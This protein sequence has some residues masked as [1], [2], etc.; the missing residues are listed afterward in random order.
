MRNVAIY[1]QGNRLI[2]AKKFDIKNNILEDVI[3]HSQDKS[4]NIMSKIQAKKMLWKN[5]KWLG[6]D[7]VIYEIDKAGQFI[8]NPK[9]YEEKRIFITETPLDF[10]N[11]QWQ[12][13]I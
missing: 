1:G 8:G 2:F 11:N 13:Q 4:Q 7:V 6:N 12:P 3:M 10:V 5:K 9:I